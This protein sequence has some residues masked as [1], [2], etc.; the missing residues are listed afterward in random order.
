[1]EINYT[2]A[3]L[4]S[5]FILRVKTLRQLENKQLS[6]HTL[7]R[8]HE[9]NEKRKEIDEMMPIIDTP[10]LCIWSKLLQG[11]SVKVVNQ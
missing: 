8:Q 9:I 11:E 5:K 1:M 4:F 2:T 10:A 3:K 7:E 6:G